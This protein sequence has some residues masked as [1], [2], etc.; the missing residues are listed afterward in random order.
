MGIQDE[1]KEIKELVKRQEEG[2]EKKFKYPFG[3]KVGK[4]QR[5][6]NFITVLKLNEN[7]SCEFV[8][9]QIKDQVF[10][11]EGIP[12]LAAAGYVMQDRGNPLVILPSWSVEPFSPVDN[13]KQSLINGSNSRGYQV[14]LANMEGEAIKN[15]P[16][17]GWLKWVGILGLLGI[18]IYAIMT[19][20]GI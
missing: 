9:R 20:G 15:K 12:R 16:S 4:A 18:V 5:K 11:E 10:W 19:G 3:K 6:K 13:F 7:G 2:K 8:K 17:V 14:L 1:L